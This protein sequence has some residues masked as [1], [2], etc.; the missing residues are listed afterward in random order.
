V[1]LSVAINSDTHYDVVKEIKKTSANGIVPSQ[2]CFGKDETVNAI[3][4][5]M[6][7]ET[8]WP[9]HIISRLPGAP[10]PVAKPVRTS[11]TIELTFRQREVF[12]LVARRGLSNKKIAKILSISES[13]VKIH[14]SAIMKAYKVQ[15]RTQLALIR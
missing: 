6:R 13:T 14:V 12:G 2:S 15:N 10:L 4:A 9:K 3:D 7:N 5:I 8:Y 1:A 11:S